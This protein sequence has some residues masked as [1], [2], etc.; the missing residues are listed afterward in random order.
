MFTYTRNLVERK[1][2]CTNTTIRNT[3]ST[4]IFYSNM[5]TA[6]TA[7]EAEERDRQV[8]AP[9]TVSPSCL[10]AYSARGIEA[11]AVLQEEEEEGEGREEGERC[12]FRVV[13]ANA[14]FQRWVGSLDRL[15]KLD[16]VECLV[17]AE[18]QARCVY[19]GVCNLSNLPF[20]AVG[21]Q[22]YECASFVQSV[23]LQART[24]QQLVYFDVYVCLLCL[25]C[26]YHTDFLVR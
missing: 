3:E 24:L 5:T 13:E 25:C 1:P 23:V 21:V 18:D 19:V 26:Y 2:D 10:E 14:R 22:L 9:S 8:A 15:R 12:R 6:V 20:T 7:S 11:I 16:F 17:K 4:P